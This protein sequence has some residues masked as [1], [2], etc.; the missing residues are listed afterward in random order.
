MAIRK[1]YFSYRG[2]LGHKGGPP[3]FER[4]LIAGLQP[5]AGAEFMENSRE[6]YE[7]ERQDN[8]KSA[9][10]RSLSSSPHIEHEHG[11]NLRSRT[12]E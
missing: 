9:D 10:L 5:V 1:P 3:F 12:A 6:A 4:Q 2:L 8:T 7:D 11:H